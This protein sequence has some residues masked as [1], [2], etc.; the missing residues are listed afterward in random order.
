MSGTVT[1]L[2]RIWHPWY[3]FLLL[4]L[5]SCSNGVP[6][7]TPL[8]NDALVLA[9][10][11]S[12]TFGTGAS[13]AESYPAVLET[14][15]HHRVINA[16]VPGEVTG[17]GLARLPEFLNQH[18][19]ALL[20][21]CHGGNDLLRKTGEKQAASNVRAMIDMARKRGTDV[22]LIGVPKPGLSASV[23]RFYAE[24]AKEFDVPYE[25][26]V[27]SDIL[28]DGSL[29]SDLIHPNARGYAKLAE[30]IAALLSKAKAI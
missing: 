6:S 27:L 19:P 28:S 5:S 24:I 18:Q 29:K 4:F 22:V 20:I 9:F 12:I 15:I 17:Q 26:N 2:K 3:V 23:A 8:D 10:G 13:M 11:D 7:I 14:L 16:G 21:L 25:G 30:S 1:Q